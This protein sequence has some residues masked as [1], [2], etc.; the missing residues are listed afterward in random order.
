MRDVWVIGIGQTPIGE[1]WDKSLQDLAVDALGAACL[2]AGVEKPDALYVSNML[3]GQLIGQKHLGALIAQGMGWTGIEAS[4]VEAAC[5]SGGVAF[6]AGVR[7]VASG[8]M[9]TVAV[10]GVEKMT[11]ETSG[12]TVTAGLATAADADYEVD[13]GVTFVALNALMMK[14]YM[15]EHGVP[16][17]VFGEFSV[18]AH[19]NGAA[20]PNA[21][22]QHAITVDTYLNAPMIAPPINL[23]DSSPICDG[24]AA[25][26][27]ASREVA[28]NLS[29]VVPVRVLADSTA[30]D[31]LSLHGRRNPIFL[32]AARASAFRAYEQARIGPEDIDLHVHPEPGGVG[33]R[34]A[35][36]GHEAGGGGRDQDR[37]AVADLHDGRPESTRPPGGGNRRVRD[38]RRGDATARPGRREPG[39]RRDDR[40]GPEHRGHR[41]DGRHPHPGARINKNGE[42]ARRLAVGI[43]ITVL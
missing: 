33:F 1:L 35:G 9:D 8:L 29:Q 5:A 37:R 2:D 24:A 36:A 43:S 34:R 25:V 20:N 21:M 41:G 15:H 13:Q 18:N 42:A 19:A 32:D 10:C 30:T 38:R 6:Q 14:R 22:F 3:A 23:Y 16:H 28:Q 11:D 27:L 26:I 7:A 4:A 40:D 12:R 31:C 39:V 17:R